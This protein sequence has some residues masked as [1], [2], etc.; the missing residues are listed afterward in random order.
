MAITELSSKKIII[1]LYNILRKIDIKNT[2]LT[3]Y[4]NTYV[5]NLIIIFILSMK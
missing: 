1:N 5:M 3:S 4:K 2:N